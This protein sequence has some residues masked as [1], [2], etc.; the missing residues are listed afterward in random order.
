[1][2]PFSGERSWIA[3]V[4]EII[5][6]FLAASITHYWMDCNVHCFIL[7]AKSFFSKLNN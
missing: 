2:Q 3:V 1:M 4:P 6:G 5:H 7:S